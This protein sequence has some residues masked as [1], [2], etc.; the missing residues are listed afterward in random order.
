MEDLSSPVAVEERRGGGGGGGGVG[1]KTGDGAG[2]EGRSRLRRSEQSPSP[3]V[4]DGS[5]SRHLVDNQIKTKTNQRSRKGWKLLGIQRR[6]RRREG[7][8]VLLPSP[9]HLLLG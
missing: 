9:A 1:N 6:S 8:R 4:H 2:G 3:P 5:S 7:R